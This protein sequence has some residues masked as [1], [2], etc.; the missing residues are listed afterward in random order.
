MKRNQPGGGPA[1]DM[2]TD[3]FRPDPIRCL[4]P[5]VGQIWTHLST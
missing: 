4:P 2:M 3:I 1:E 5:F